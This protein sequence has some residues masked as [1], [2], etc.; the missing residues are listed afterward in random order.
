[1][2][3]TPVIKIRLIDRRI[4]LLVGFDADRDE[5]D[6]EI[7]ISWGGS[8]TEA[9]FKG[10]LRKEGIGEETTRINYG[11][12]VPGVEVSHDRL[13][14]C[15][16]EQTPRKRGREMYYDAN[17]VFRGANLQGT[18]SPKTKQENKIHSKRSSRSRRNFVPKQEK[19]PGLSRTLIPNKKGMSARKKSRPRSCPKSGARKQHHRG[20]EGPSPQTLVTT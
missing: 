8:S 10:G 15:K 13:H 11:V 14:D 5:G 19:C 9:C 18:S 2:N 12:R 1:M 20:G 7:G 17:K 4:R 6:R 3:R 16:G